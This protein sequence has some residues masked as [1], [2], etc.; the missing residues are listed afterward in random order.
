MPGVSYEQRAGHG[1][2][3]FD[4]PDAPEAVG[5][6]GADLLLGGL[7]FVGFAQVGQG[8]LRRLQCYVEQ[9]P[10][11]V[12]VPGVGRGQ[13]N[14]AAVRGHGG[15]I[16]ALNGLTQPHQGLGDVVVGVDAEHFT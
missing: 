4:S 1:G 5:I 6:R 12:V 9:V 7:R 13:R 15:A 10:E 11:V 14:G 3:F 2:A 8:V 16:V